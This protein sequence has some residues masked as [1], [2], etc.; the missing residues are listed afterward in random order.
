MTGFTA[1]VNPCLCVE[2]ISPRRSLAADNM[3]SDNMPS[4]WHNV[5][6]FTKTDEIVQPNI[7]SFGQMLRLARTSG[8]AHELIPGLKMRCS[9]RCDGSS[10]KQ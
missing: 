1:T 3:P 10:T 9:P 5:H 4:L 2:V 7:P 6:N 8:N